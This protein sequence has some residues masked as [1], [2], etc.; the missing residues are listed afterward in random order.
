MKR[1]YPAYLFWMGFVG[2]LF[3]RFFYLF[4][5]AV[6]LLIIGIWIPVCLLTGIVLLAVDVAVSFTA[7]LI[8][9]K[10]VLKESDNP[11]FREF[12]N[13]VLSPNWR[14]ELAQFREKH[15]VDHEDPL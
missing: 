13:A 10:T 1:A 6:I 12:Q 4:I 2:N 11:N 14:E 7:Q 3:G 5:P 8:I 15:Y 9:R